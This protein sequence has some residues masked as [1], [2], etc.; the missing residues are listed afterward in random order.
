MEP[1]KPMRERAF[2]R[3]QE[4]DLKHPR[5]VDLITT[6]TLKQNKLPSFIDRLGGGY[7]FW[8]V[9]IL[10]MCETGIRTETKIHTCL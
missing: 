8:Q 3:H 5:L 10:F 9:P 7:P 1:S 4:H 2:Q 6:K